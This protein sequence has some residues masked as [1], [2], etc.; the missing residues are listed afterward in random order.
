MA[1]IKIICQHCGQHLV[2]DSAASGQQ[3]ICPSCSTPFAIPVVARVAPPA[4]P[5]TTKGPVPAPVKPQNQPADNPLVGQLKGVGRVFYGLGLLGGLFGI[6]GLVSSMMSGDGADIFWIV[7]ILICGGI[8]TALNA[9]F[10]FMAESVR[11][12]R[13]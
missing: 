3:A 4:M 6:W 11:Q 13:G 9:T 10:K 7:V 12:K 5:A 1:D 8:G 2:V